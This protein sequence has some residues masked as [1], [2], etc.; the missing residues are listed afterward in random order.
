MRILV[1]DKV[2]L[3][4]RLVRHILTV[5]GP[6]LAFVYKTYLDGYDSKLS[7]LGFGIVKDQSDED[8]MQ[9]F[10]FDLKKSPGI[11]H[12]GEL[13]RLLSTDG[14]EKLCHDVDKL[15]K[16]LAVYDARLE[17]ECDFQEIYRSY[18][19]DNG[20]PDR[21]ISLQNLFGKYFPN[22]RDEFVKLSSLSQINLDWAKRPLLNGL[23]QDVYHEMACLI[24][25]DPLIKRS[26]PEHSGLRLNNS[27]EPVK[28]PAR[29]RKLRKKQWNILELTYRR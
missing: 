23:L 26:P 12:N 24:E 21:S 20:L 19:A 8:D 3:S 9:V 15:K 18:M 2:S 27:L 14:I 7:I 5:N 22:K 29:R 1:V 4:R 6:R 11:L 13:W 16:I 28:L 25:L 10:I 17:R